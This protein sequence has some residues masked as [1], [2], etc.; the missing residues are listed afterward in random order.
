[1]DN[2]RAGAPDD[3]L[4]MA[5]QSAAAAAPSV[6]SVRDG[7]VVAAVQRVEP[8]SQPQ[9]AARTT[10][11]GGRSADRSLLG[12]AL[13]LKGLNFVRANM[14]GVA[15]WTSVEKRFNQ[16]Q[17]DGHL[18]RSRF[19]KC[20]GLEGSD[21][22]AMLLFDALA[23]RQNISSHNI[24][25]A[26]LRQ[27]WDQISS[28]SAETRLQIFFDMVV[29]NTDGRITEDDVKEI[30]DLSASSNKLLK[31]KER[32]ADYAHLIM[33][34]LDPG[35]VGHIRLE[36]LK[37]MLMLRQ[38]QAHGH[39]VVNQMLRESLRPT[40]EP[41]SL[42][43]R[44]RS[45]HYFIE[46]YWKHVWVMLL[47]LSICAGL[48]VWKFLQYRRRFLFE[49]MGYCIC[50]AKGG[51]ET[52]KFNMALILL[53]VCRNTITWIRNFTV[54]TRVVP[55]DDSLNF[56]QVIA[57]GITIGMGLHII[58]HLTCDFQRV[59]H[60]ADAEYA[61]LA[62]YFG[63]T[64]DR[65][66]P[67]Y[68]WFLRSTEGWT[69]LTMLALMAIAFTLALPSFR[70][71]RMWRL[72]R[73]LRDLAGFNAFWYTHHLF[74]IVYA[75]LIVHGHFLYLTQKWYKNTTWMYLVVPMC[76]Y[77]C[78]RLTRLLRST[79]LSVKILKVVVYPANML[80]L[81][82]SKPRGFE[83][84]S[85]QYI[86][87]NCPAISL[88]QWHPFCI[89]SAPQDSYVS[90]HIRTRGDWTSRLR[91][92]FSEVRQPPMERKSGLLGAE[93][94]CNDNDRPNP[95]Y[96]KVLI[97]GPYSLAVQDY[98]QYQAV[99]LISL[100]IGVAPMMS[101]VKD[102]INNMKQLRYDLESG[103]TNNSVSSSSFCT[104]RVY[105]YWVTREEAS[106]DWI[107]SI[108]DE[109]A[110]T[111][112]KGF[113]EFHTYCSSIYEEGDARSELIAVL[114][115]LNFAKTGVDIIT[116][117][118]VKTHFGRPNWCNVYKRIALNHRDQRV[119][120]FYSGEP[121]LVQQLRELA[122]DFS[123]KTTTKFEFH[124]MNF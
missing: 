100:G 28:T 92:I 35:N 64:R 54:V 83:Y 79:M 19:G 65:R 17:V 45:T 40:A 62:R 115:S 5:S 30:I 18:L 68:W 9:V 41:S 85:G 72:P 29:K 84:K 81:H 75:L 87:L 59:L 121:V 4:E 117:T 95:C 12:A 105:F 67:S 80:S 49:V 91:T 3:V 6:S 112:K 11:R 37:E 97:D 86:F 124:G 33:E 42:R 44:Y 71:D 63:T 57:V 51:A 2:H 123:W 78:E 1:M 32:A 113:V 61:P 20:V 24:T 50:V 15:G 70:R 53:P 76:L 43:R 118:S 108:M 25:K 88:L 77:A 69:G 122:Q 98:K 21:E 103:L 74:I 14:R 13:T 55:I 10:P 90:V 110:E 94:D 104:P 39:S 99:L 114:Q 116:G 66:P 47:W 36:N 93:Y 48:F 22:F 34:E 82:F 120:V 106:S 73:L 107:R 38:A 46:N 102:V 27:F 96:P 26:E 31:I 119:G 56:H 16:L 109:V 8:D 89:T 7:S 60:A 52:L 111:D 101:I 58:P 23:R